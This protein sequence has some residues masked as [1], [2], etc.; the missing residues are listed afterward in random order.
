MA[1]KLMI[2]WP[3]QSLHTEDATLEGAEGA[4]MPLAIRPVRP[5]TPI[6]S[7]QHQTLACPHFA[8]HASAA[9]AP[10]HGMRL[11][12]ASILSA[13]EGD[14]PAAA[15][16]VALPVEYEAASDSL[17]AKLRRSFGQATSPG[18]EVTTTPRPCCMLLCKTRACCAAHSAYVMPLWALPCCDLQQGARCA[19]MQLLPM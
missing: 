8:A 12:P 19:A 14:L 17:A 7:L 5:G 18:V 6:A 1:L 9:A 3:R 15:L 13:T 4:A 10:M 2:V 16:H 11:W